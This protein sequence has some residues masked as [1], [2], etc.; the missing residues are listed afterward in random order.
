MKCVTY[1]H[2]LA[3]PHGGL[4]ALAKKIGVNPASLCNFAKGKPVS[5]NVREKIQKH[6]CGVSLSRLQ[7]DVLDLIADAQ[8]Q[9]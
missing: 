6:F 5:E 3:A 1:L 8:L 2:A 9:R 7:V 4:G